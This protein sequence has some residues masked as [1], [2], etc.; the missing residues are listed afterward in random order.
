MKDFLTIAT[1][2]KPQGIRGEVKVLALTDSPE[3]LQ[4]FTRVY[5][6]GKPCKILKVRAQ[7]GNCAFLTLSGIADR[8]AAALPQDTFYIADVIGCRVLSGDSEIGVVE[9]IT[10]AKTD[11]YAV[12]LN[13]GK[14]LV[15]PAVQ[16]LIESVD[17]AEKTVRVNAERLGEVAF[18]E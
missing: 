12:A 3:D 11:V 4:A 16:G 15:F 6:G 9:E 13:S 14:R 1:I 17:L 5:V 18:E 10:P 2:V 8:N 7:N